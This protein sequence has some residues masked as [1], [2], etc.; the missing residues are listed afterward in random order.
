[1]LFIPVKIF[2]DALVT[3]FLLQQNVDN[4]CTFL[5]VIKTWWKRDGNDDV[6]KVYCWLRLVVIIERYVWH[7]QSMKHPRLGTRRVIVDSLQ[8]NTF[9]PHF[10]EVW[11]RK[12]DKFDI[13][14]I[15]KDQG[16]AWYLSS[17]ERTLFSRSGKISSSFFS[18]KTLIFFKTFLV[19]FSS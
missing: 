6:I 15:C 16:F 19:K 9:E 2:F 1:M 3:F 12:R 17:Q 8:P 7:Y 10:L 13:F 4:R 11:L 14:E 5:H 18:Q